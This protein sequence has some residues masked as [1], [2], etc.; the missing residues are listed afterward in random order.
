M[1]AGADAFSISGISPVSSRN[2]SSG[3]GTPVPANGAKPSSNAGS[4][5]T[6]LA[7]ASS[8]ANGSPRSNAECRPA[9]TSAN[10]SGSS[11]LGAADSAT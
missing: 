3:F 9:A 7:A 2:S 8:A 1:A 5:P 4:T 6:A 11:V 10:R